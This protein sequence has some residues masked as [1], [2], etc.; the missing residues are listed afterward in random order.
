MANFLTACPSAF[1]S[2]TTLLL[3]RKKQLKE[4]SR[5]LT[6]QIHICSLRLPTYPYTILQ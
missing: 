1:S 5:I 3:I 4:K 6:H 2:N